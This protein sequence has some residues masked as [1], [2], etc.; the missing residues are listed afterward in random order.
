V[1]RIGLGY[2]VGFRR[3]DV[4]AGSRGGGSSSAFPFQSPRNHAHLSR[5]I[6]SVA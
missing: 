5:D 3:R 6:H 4:T 2:T 1:R